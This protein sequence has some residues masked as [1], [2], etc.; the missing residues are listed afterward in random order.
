[1]IV[2]KKR[3]LNNIRVIAKLPMLFVSLIFIINNTWFIDLSFGVTYR[4]YAVALCF[5]LSF[6]LLINSKLLFPIRYVLFFMPILS[7][8]FVLGIINRTPDI[9]GFI[10]TISFWLNFFV[11]FFSVRKIYYDDLINLCYFFIASQFYFLLITDLLNR[12]IMGRGLSILIET[13]T[14]ISIFGFILLSFLPKEKKDNRHFFLVI[15]FS[16]IYF[17]INVYLDFNFGYEK[18]QKIQLGLILFSILYFVFLYLIRKIMRNGRLLGILTPIN[19]LLAIIIFFVIYFHNIKDILILIRS[20]SSYLRF[21]INVSMLREMSNISMLFGK[22]F[23]SSWKQFYVA[24][25]HPDIFTFEFQEMY[26]HSGLIVLFFEYGFLGLIVLGYYFIKYLS[27]N[28]NFI[29]SFYRS[30]SSNG[31]ILSWLWL[32]LILFFLLQNSLYVQGI[33]S[34]DMYFQSNS[35][36][37][38][39]FTVLIFKAKTRLINLY[40]LKEVKG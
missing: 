37:Y 35:L 11:V 17:I 7:L 29:R 10:L 3:T 33:P 14:P 13:I 24:D 28:S 6:M 4:P 1:M 8:Y 38:I 5:L 36:S 15:L 2:I 40:A 34:G 27:L 30:Y 22:G 18:T 31:F 32:G 9:S 25:L 39:F 19:I 12:L 23:G 26:P 21:A 16:L 20:S